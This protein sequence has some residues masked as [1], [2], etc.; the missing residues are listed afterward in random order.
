MYSQLALGEHLKE[1]QF[2]FITFD[3][4]PIEI[5]MSEAGSFNTIKN[6]Y[7]KYSV[8]VESGL[9]KVFEENAHV[10]KKADHLEL[11][12]S[13]HEKITAKYQR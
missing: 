4:D 2:R 7:N 3:V 6:L 10:I 12:L 13:K 1:N 11:Q 5:S 8:Q 9:V